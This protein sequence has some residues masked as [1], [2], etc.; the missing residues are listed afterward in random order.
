MPRDGRREVSE[1]W[2]Q[3][4]GIERADVRAWA[5]YD[6]ANSA[7]VTTIV[8]AV[9]P[10]YFSTVAAA[11]LPPAV[12]T[13]RFA[14]ATTV[15][16]A[17]IAVLA[18]LLGALADA[19]GWKKR[20]L[21]GFLLI[22]V[23]ATA[24]MG[25]V[26]RGQWLGGAILFGIA[27]IGAWGTFVFYDSLLPHVAHTGGEMDRASTA[28]YALGYLG[29][30]LMLALN[31]AWISWPQAFGFADSAS[32]AR[33][34]FVSVA[35]WWAVFSIPLFRRVPEPAVRVSPGTLIHLVSISKLLRGLV[36]TLR[37]LRRYREAL[38]FL[39]AFLV[40]NDG[41]G[42]VI[43]MAAIYGAELG[44]PQQS[45]LAAILLV[46]LIGV[47]CAFAFGALA[48]RVGIKPAILFSLAVYLAISVLGGL[49]SHTWQFY[50]LAVL[51]GSV[52]GGS[53]ALSRSLFARLIPR[54]RSAE[55]FAFF[56]ISDKVAGI[57]GPAAFAGVSSLAGTSRAG[58]MV[59]GVF[60][61]VGA[62]LLRQVDIEAGQTAA[63]ADDSNAFV[64][65][66]AE[67]SSLS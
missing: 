49:L 8:A 43:R 55:F 46:Q 6:W 62:L 52:Q 40:Y 47:P 50:V 61:V 7:F 31:L 14:L 10:V 15:A 9:F 24:A 12:A 45:L 11:G 22:G 17:I 27:N 64:A 57:V 39:L 16:L 13:R 18:P 38:L 20:L 53:Q 41:I 58:V 2:L 60:F 32:A 36:R 35:V 4:L 63:L 66:G 44:L 30:G 42:T 19:A 33:A 59:V 37:D 48:V 65:G 23:A 1:R 29:G 5:I 67:R 28:G 54:A 56:S 26:Q 51:V 3:R 25:G 34:S 21:G